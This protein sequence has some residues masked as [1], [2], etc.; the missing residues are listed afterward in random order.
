MQI[1]SEQQAGLAHLTK[2][3]QKD[4]KDLAVIMGNGISGGVAGED[5][6]AHV[7]DGDTSWGSKSTLRVSS[8]R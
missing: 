8:L 6:S 2:I 7:R 3:L 4:V 5:S 1:L